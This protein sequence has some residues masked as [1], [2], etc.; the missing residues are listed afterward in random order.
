MSLIARCHYNE[1]ITM[2]YY[3]VL[4]AAVTT[5]DAFGAQSFPNR[6][7]IGKIIIIHG[8]RVDS[9]SLQ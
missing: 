7:P 8:R 3:I 1:L 9:D 2:T 4:L 5:I 6:I